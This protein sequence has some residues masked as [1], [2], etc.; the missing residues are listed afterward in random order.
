[1][2]LFVRI[3]FVAALLGQILNFIGNFQ[4]RRSALA[5]HGEWLQGVLDM[6]TAPPWWI[7]ATVMLVSLC[8][9]LWF[10]RCSKAS[11]NQ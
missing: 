3:W 1:M 7:P 2:K 4:T 5:H 11:T 8:L 10:E 6:A 9:W